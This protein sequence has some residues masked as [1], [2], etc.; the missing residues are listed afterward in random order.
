ME[1]KGSLS[2]L[3][4]PATCPY[5]GPDPVHAPTSGRSILILF[6]HLCLCLPKCLF[7][8]GFPTTSLYT[9]LLSPIRAARPAYLILLDFITRTTYG[10]E[11]RT[12]SS[13]LCSFLQTLILVPLGLPSSLFPSGFPTTTLYTPL[14]PPYVLHAPPISFFSI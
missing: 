2:H 11:Y 12:L 14:L 8:S 6:F 3:Q 4:V 13:S 5:S 1:H 9:P 7:P 10:E